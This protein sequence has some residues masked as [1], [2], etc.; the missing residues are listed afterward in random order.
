VSQWNIHRRE[1][2]VMALKYSRRDREGV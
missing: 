1:A 2:L